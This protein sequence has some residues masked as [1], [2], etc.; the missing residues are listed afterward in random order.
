MEIKR[1]LK[2][3]PRG[4]DAGIGNKVADDKNG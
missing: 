4:L 3:V 1:N 2:T